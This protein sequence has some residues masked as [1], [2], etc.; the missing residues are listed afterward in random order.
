MDMQTNV[1]AKCLLMRNCQSLPNGLYHFISPS[2]IVCGLQLLCILANSCYCQA[3]FHF[4]VLLDVGSCII[5]AL[6]SISFLDCLLQRACSDLLCNFYW[7]AIVL[8]CEICSQI[9]YLSSQKACALH[10]FIVYG[11]FMSLMVSLEGHLLFC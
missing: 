10:L 6:I 3:N 9:L 2:E 8:S 1:C 11:F 5:R 7:A 4:T